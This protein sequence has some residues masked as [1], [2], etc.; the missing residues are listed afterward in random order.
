MWNLYNRIEYGVIKEIA[1]LMNNLRKGV[2]RMQALKLWRQ[3]QNERI[4]AS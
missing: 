1:P 2:G 3:G 4:S